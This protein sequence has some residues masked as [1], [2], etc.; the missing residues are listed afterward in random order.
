M[1]FVQIP[2][3][4]LRPNTGQIKG[5][6]KNPRSWTRSDM[7]K[8][9]ASIRETPEL[10]EARGLIVLPCAGAYVVLCGNMRLEAGKEIGYKEMPCF[11]LPESTPI[12][13]LKEIVIKDNGSFGSWD[14]DMLANE[15][16]DLA[17]TDWG[18]PAWNMAGE[19]MDLNLK[20]NESEKSSSALSNNFQMTFVFPVEEREI[21][22]AYIDA[23]GKDSIVNHIID[24][25]HSC[26]VEEEEDA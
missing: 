10:L 5:L 15:W 1:Q 19:G 21:I 2:I 22:E 23:K 8:L 7:D 14:W 26:G 25:A 12:E 6:P 9:V 4:Q 20:G 16:D 18:V 24:I 11:I 13:K 3:G 17:L